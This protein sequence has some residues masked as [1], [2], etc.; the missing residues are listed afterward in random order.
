MT[1]VILPELIRKLRAHAETSY[2]EEG[3]GLLLGT[4]DGDTRVV[5]SILE[6]NNAREPG[7]RHNRYLIT[8]QDMLRAEDEAAQRGMDV[9]G[10]FHSHPDHPARPSDFDL[11]WA[12]PWFSYLIT[13]VASGTTVECRSWRLA[14]NRGSFSEEPIEIHTPAPLPDIKAS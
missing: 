3:A 12:M 7:A 10:V 4:A 6:L 2:P 1:L 11:K 13:S 5:E 8:P 14:E 9:L